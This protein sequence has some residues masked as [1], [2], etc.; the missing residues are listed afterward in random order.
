MEK[1]IWPTKVMRCTQ[2]YNSSYS[3]VGSYAFDDG[4]TNGVSNEYCYAPYSGT[5]MRIYAYCNAIWFQSDGQ[6][7]CADG[8]AR[9]LVTCIMHT[10]DVDLQDLGIAVGKHFNQG[11]P[12]A[13]EGTK[14]NVTGAHSHIEVGLAPFSGTGWY[15]SNYIDASGNNVWIINNQLIPN[16]IFFLSEDTV[17]LNDGGYSWKT[18]YSELSWIDLENSAIRVI[19]N[20]CEYFYSTDIYDIVGKLTNG[21]MYDVVAVSKTALDGFVWL[22]II[23]NGTQYYA[24]YEKDRMILQADVYIPYYREGIDVSKYQGT[25]DWEQVKSAGYSFAMIRA[26]SSNDELGTYLDPY[27]E[28]NVKNAQ[29]AGLDVGAYI[30]TYAHSND[31]IDEE[32]SIA[33]PALNKYKFQLPIFFDFEDALI[34]TNG[35]DLNTSICRHGFETLLSNGYCPGLY[36]G[37]KWGATYID[38]ASLQDYP[39]WLAHWTSQTD[40]TL[41]YGIWQYANDGSV[42]GVSGNVDLDHGLI[43]YEPYMTSNGLNNLS[44]PDNIHVQSVF[45]DP[46]SATILDNGEITLKAVISPSDASNQK[47]TWSTSNPSIATVSNAGVVSGVSEGN[48]VITVTSEDGSKTSTCNITV[49]SSAIMPT[50]LSLLT[51]TASILTGESFT[52]LPVFTPNNTTEKTLVW[53]SNNEQIATVKNGVVVGIGNGVATITAKTV[54]G[55]SASATITVSEIPVENILLNMSQVLM[56]VGESLLLSVIFTPLNATDKSIDWESESPDIVSVDNGYV[57]ALKAGV[58]RVS[59]TTSNGKKAEYLVFSRIN[60]SIY[61]ENVN[62]RIC[63]RG[64]LESSWAASDPIPLPGE[65]CISYGVGIKYGDGIHRWSE[66][67]Y[68]FLA[69]KLITQ[70]EIDSLFDDEG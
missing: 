6:V 43:D 37:K 25:I 10:N 44:S 57:T 16:E 20:N 24:A 12:I 42:A 21:A 47:V 66:L 33:L 30:Y 69:Y 53:T 2:G 34:A 27:F 19:V 49:L 8:I 61:G 39:Y 56:V 36:T 45:V 17:V 5:V 62:V 52:L 59:A 50:S 11:D 1:A 46:S 70:E 68:T 13:R 15:K 41:E 35:K 29:A 18:S 60:E 55:I 28:T 32:I 63:P 31:E 23:V 9:Q 48:V 14:G 4:M 58:A 26:V 64:D 38:A 7:M 22:K 40:S 67:D 3:H 65:E 51:N 54:N